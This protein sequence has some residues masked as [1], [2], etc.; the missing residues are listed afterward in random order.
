MATWGYTPQNVF[1][2]SVTYDVRVAVVTPATRTVGLASP[3]GIRAFRLQ[4]GVVT[5]SDLAGMA[6]F[7]TARRGPFESF[8]WINP[9]DHRAYAVRFDGAMRAE[10]FTP[11]LWRGEVAFEVVDG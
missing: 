9:N 6:A 4:Y 5:S 8:S 2:E 1:A 3:N 10:L 7:Y 11:G